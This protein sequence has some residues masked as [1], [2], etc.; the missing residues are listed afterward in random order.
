MAK[1]AERPEELHGTTYRIKAGC[2]NLY[3]T[4]NLDEKGVALECFCRLGKA[5]GCANSQ[6]EAIGRL[7]SYALRIGGD[8][9]EIIENLIG[10]NCHTPVM[11]GKTRVHSCSDGI[12]QVLRNAVNS[13][14]KPKK[15]KSNTFF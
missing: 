8:I 2:G 11:N 13:A 6:T 7:I 14:G 5:G 3:I 12:A 15:M 9:N 4:L 10:I 1:K